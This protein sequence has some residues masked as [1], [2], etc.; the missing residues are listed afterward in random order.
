M[1]NSIKE[2]IFP[3]K[4][5][6]LTIEPTDDRIYVV[7]LLDITTASDNERYGFIN[8]LVSALGKREN[9]NRILEQD[10]FDMLYSFAHY[11]NCLSMRDKASVLDIVTRCKYLN[12][13]E[14]FI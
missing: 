5:E 8:N 11:S 1:E 9:L 3:I 7:D 6:Q 14:I 13:I 4:R 12:S 2:F 10:Q